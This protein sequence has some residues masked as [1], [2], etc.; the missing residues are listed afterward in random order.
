MF[1]IYSL[2]PDVPE[3]MDRAKW[4]FTHICA[5]NRFEA[6]VVCVASPLFPTR[7]HSGAAVD[8][9]G[10]S[11]GEAAWVGIRRCPCKREG[12]VAR[13]GATPASTPCRLLGSKA[14]PFFSS[15]SGGARADFAY[16]GL[17]R[18][19]QTGAVLINEGRGTRSPA[20]DEG[21]VSSGIRRK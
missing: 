15:M 19:W 13:A 3:T 20:A 16:V 5:F 6:M 10:P 7:T 21:F 9:R 17:D 2:R 4:Q 1:G 14:K 11:R 18:R 8:E 12:W